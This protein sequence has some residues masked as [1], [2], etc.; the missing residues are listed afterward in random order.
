MLAGL[1]IVAIVV[2]LTAIAWRRPNRAVVAPAASPATAAS[3]SNE[4]E[5]VVL[6]GW[7]RTTGGHR[8][9]YRGRYT[10]EVELEDGRKV[11][12]T[13][14]TP[15]GRRQCVRVRARR[16]GQQIVVISLEIPDQ[17]CPE[18]EPYSR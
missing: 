7:V 13:S 4:G 9:K 17:Q 11:G 12:F 6:L 15:Y 10:H 16:N 8:G 18:P 3:G 5:E 1:A 2:S 14:A